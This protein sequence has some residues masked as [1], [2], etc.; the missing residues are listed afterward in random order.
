MTLEIKVLPILTE[1]ALVKPLP[2]MVTWVPP[3]DVPLV[4]VRLVIDGRGGA[5]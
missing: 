3:A 1:V 5:V 2:V 4:G